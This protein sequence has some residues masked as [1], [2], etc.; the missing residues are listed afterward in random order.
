MTHD[1]S[2]ALTGVSG[3]LATPFDET[4]EIAPDLQRAIVDRAV[5]AGVH[6]LTANGN[7]GIL[8]IE[9]SRPM[10]TPMPISAHGRF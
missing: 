4:G 3:I 1:L 7:T 6:V 5:D 9:A 10:A 8:T 2:R